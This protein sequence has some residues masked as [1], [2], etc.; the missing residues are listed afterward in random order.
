MVAMRKFKYAE[1]LKENFL[2]I[3]YFNSKNQL[4]SVWNV[5]IV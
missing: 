2:K 5:I 4:K 1:E 3:I